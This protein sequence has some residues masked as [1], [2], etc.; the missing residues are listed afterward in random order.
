MPGTEYDTLPARSPNIYQWSVADVIQWF[1]ELQLQQDYGSVVRKNDIDGEVLERI[2]QHLDGAEAETSLWASFLNENVQ[3]LG[4]RIRITAGCRDLLR[5]ITTA[6]VKTKR[7]SDGFMSVKRKSL[8]NKNIFADHTSRQNSQKSLYQN[9]AFG[10]DTVVNPLA[11]EPLSSQGNIQGV[12]WSDREGR[13]PAVH[14]SGNQPPTTNISNMVCRSLSRWRG[15][16]K[17]VSIVLAAALFYEFSMRLYT[18][19]YSSLFYWLPLALGYACLGLLIPWW[20]YIATESDDAAANSQRG[21]ELCRYAGLFS[22][23]LVV[24]SFFGLNTPPYTVS[25]PPRLH[26]LSLTNSHTCPKCALYT[27]QSPVLRF[28]SSTASVVAW[29]FFFIILIECFL[30]LLWKYRQH[31]RWGRSF[32]L[33]GLV[34]VVFHLL[35]LYYILVLGG[36]NKQASAWKKW[37]WEAMMLLIVLVTFKTACY[38]SVASL[39]GQPIRREGVYFFY[40][41]SIC[42]FFPWWCGGLMSVLS[43]VFGRSQMGLVAILIIWSMFLVVVY[44]NLRLIASRCM[45]YVRMPVAILSMQLCGDLFSEMVFLDFSISSWEFWFVLFFDVF[46]LVMRDADLVSGFYR[47]ALENASDLTTSNH[48]LWVYLSLLLFPNSCASG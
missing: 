27:L 43:R 23:G 44:L 48:L 35:C 9:P 3:S 6:T 45:P 38:D 15:H 4:D 5:P 13:V 20:M 31:F 34:I 28:H 7:R 26:T 1:G 42:L 18:A 24:T 2:A 39:G 11:R 29:I 41:V 47:V 33:M 32:W 30:L 21:L 37:I 40:L 12:T 22:A 17:L 19:G 14:V 10:V 46:L 25:A 8:E 36:Q 16:L